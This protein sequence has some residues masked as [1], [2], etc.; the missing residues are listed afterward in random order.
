MKKLISACML[1][2]TVLATHAQSSN[3]LQIGDAAPPLQNVLW[4][5]GKPVTSFKKGQVYIVEM[6]AT[7]CVPC[8]K[9][10]P[11]LSG[12]AKNYAKEGVN[13]IGVFVMEQHSEKPGAKNPPYLDVVKKYVTGKGD[14]MNYNVAADLPEAFMETKWLKAAGGQ[15]VP[16]TLIVDRDGKIAYIGSDYTKI[17]E[18]VRYVAGARYNIQDAIAAHKKEK[19][20]KIEYDGRKLLLI[21]NNGGADTNFLF[22]SILTVYDGSFHAVGG[23]VITNYHLYKGYEDAFRPYMDKLQEPG[24][25]ID[26]LYRMAYGDTL[27]TDFIPRSMGDNAYPDTVARPWLVSLYGRHWPKAIVEVSDPS[28]FDWDPK[29]TVNRYNYSLKVPEGMGTAKFLQQVLRRDLDNYFG[30]EATLETRMMPCWKIIATP[31]AEKRLRKMPDSVSMKVTETAKGWRYEHA[32]MRDILWRFESSFGRTAGD[33]NAVPYVDATNI[34]GQ[35]EYDIYEV[36]EF[37]AMHKGKDLEAAKRFLHRLGLDIVKGETP[38]Q[39]V[40]IRDGNE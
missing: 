19:G 11:V 35:F 14:A 34:K 7:W 3:E 21:G 37:E 33:W 18:K 20:G 25:G 38:M 24:V 27:R 16:F 26:H 9:A 17:E 29:R 4:I 22:R 15:G 12:I 8:A 30:Y 31:E 1:L 28:Y 32:D 5:K 40:V 6:G 39:V 23:G 2:C 10:I 13:V 36:E